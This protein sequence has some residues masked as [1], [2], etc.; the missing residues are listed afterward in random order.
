MATSG[1]TGPSLTQYW[2]YFKDDTPQEGPPWETG[3][4]SFLVGYGIEFCWRVISET[5]YP[6]FTNRITAIRAVLGGTAVGHG[7]ALIP[8]SS[9][10]SSWGEVKQQGLAHPP[11]GRHE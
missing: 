9:S 5:D 2:F 11:E 7:E 1:Y 10:S 4:I 3:G 8:T 6:L